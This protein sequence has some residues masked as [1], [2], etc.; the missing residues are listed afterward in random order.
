MILSLLRILDLRNIQEIEL[1]AA[2]GINVIWGPNGSG[3][4][5]LLEA[6]YLLGRGRSFRGQQIAPLIR[7]GVDRFAV[8]GRLEQEHSPG[9]SIGIEKTREGMKARVDGKDIRKLSILART[10]PI[11][12]LTPRTHEIL[13][14][15]PA[16]RRRFI[17]WGV[18]HVEHRF[19]DVSARYMRALTQRNAALRK[20]PKTAFAWDGDLAECGEQID[21][22][23]TGYVDA[24]Q[25][26]LTDVASELMAGRSIQ[27]A[28]RAGWPK[29][30]AL[31]RRL[32]Q[33]HDDDVRRGYTGPG[34]HRADLLVELDGRAVEK[35]ASRGEQK[36]VIASLY[37]AQA[38]IN[39]KATAEKTLLLVDDLPAE[40]DPDNRERFLRKLSAL[41]NQAFVTGTDQGFSDVLPNKTLFHV[42]QGALRSVTAS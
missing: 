34:P 30:G 39:T 16:Y 4:T 14:R 1:C 35:I 36:L 26:A 19:S 12:I 15:G 28:Y 13:E 10:L 2:P 20:S 31:Y 25:T 38:T 33:A 41:G 5:T 6:I 23:R 3:K 8:F 24:L 29:D 42:E 18:F 7:S 9:H 21:A 40:L 11:Q 37:L 22:M 17:D 27:L 32:R